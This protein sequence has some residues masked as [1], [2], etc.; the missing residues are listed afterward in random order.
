VGRV[1][2]GDSV[3]VALLRWAPD[4]FLYF[5]R[6][7]GT[8]AAELWRMPVAGGALQRAAA[9]PEECDFASFSLSA[10][11][12]TGACLVSDSRPD[13]WLVERRR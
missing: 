8:T 1:D 6:R 11:T 3:R 2:G 4:G 5:S 13:L 12:K 9:L 10:D 7:I